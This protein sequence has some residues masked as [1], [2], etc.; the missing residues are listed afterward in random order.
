MTVKMK[1]DKALV[2]TNDIDEATAQQ[3]KDLSKM[4]FIHKHI[5]VMPDTHMG[6]GC[7]IGSVIAT[8]DAIIPAAVGCDIG[9]GMKAV[10]TTLTASQLPDNLHKIRTM[11]EAQIPH[12]RSNDGGVGDIGARKEITSAWGMLMDEYE[13]IITKH[14]GARN[15][16]SA[17]HLG[18]L[19]TGNHFIE[20]CLDES[21]NVWIMLHSGSRGAG[22]RIGSYFISKAK[23]EMEKMHITT[24]LP[25]SDLSYLSRYSPLYGD[26]VKAVHW[27]QKYAKINREVMMNDI[28]NILTKNIKDFGITATV[29]DCHH[30]YIAEER[31]FGENV[32]VTRKGAI[33]ANTDDLGIIPGS[34]GDKSYIVRG[35]GERNSFHSCSHG[36]GRR[37]SRSE[38]RAKF[39]ES[40]LIAQTKGIECPKDK[41]RVDEIPAAYKPIDEVMENQKDLVDIVHTLKQVINIKG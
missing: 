35:K 7:A 2:W 26:Y 21:D 32:I 16:N 13:S 38:A 29:I 14:P 39:T 1:I 22:N 3:F 23:E 30:N 24:F 15:R 27:A 25:N 33:R 6:R 9:C 10:K 17:F 19:G 40:D 37:M 41:D 4:P 31:H 18:T 5:A 8:K 36:A 12:G 11:I 34:M 20:V 28:I